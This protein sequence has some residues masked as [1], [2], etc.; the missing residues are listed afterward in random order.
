MKSYDQFLRIFR[1]IFVSL[2]MIILVS[3]TIESFCF[4]LMNQHNFINEQF[5]F[6]TLLK[7]LHQW[8]TLLPILY[9]T[10]QSLLSLDNLFELNPY[11]TDLWEVFGSI[12]VRV[13]LRLMIFLHIAIIMEFKSEDA[14]TNTSHIISILVSYVLILKSRM[15]AIGNVSIYHPS[16]D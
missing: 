15:V 12:K 10:S 14:F 11:A 7:D 4:E 8:L 2:T 3:I 1:N 16:R 13:V 5:T 6:Y 9:I